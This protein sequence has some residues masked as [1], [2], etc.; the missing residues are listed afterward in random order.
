[1]GFKLRAT[2]FYDGFLLDLYDALLGFM[3]GFC[4]GFLLVFQGILVGFVVD[5]FLLGF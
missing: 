1:M 5:C 2:G 4:A 3:M